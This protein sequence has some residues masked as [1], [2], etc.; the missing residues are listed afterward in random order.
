LLLFKV[1]RGILKLPRSLRK[2]DDRHRFNAASTRFITS[3]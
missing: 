3:L 1:G 2:E